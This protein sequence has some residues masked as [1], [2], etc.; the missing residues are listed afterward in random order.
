[1]SRNL[2][3]VGI[4]FFGMINGLPF[5]SPLYLPVLAFSAQLMQGPLFGN[6]SLIAYFASLMLS[7]G[8]II[9]SQ[10]S[11]PPPWRAR[12]SSSARKMSRARRS[13][14]VTPTRLASPYSAAVSERV[15]VWVRVAGKPA[16]GG[17]SAGAAACAS[18]GVGVRAKNCRMFLMSCICRGSSFASFQ[19]FR[20]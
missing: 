9:L 6:L 7:T 5:F 14:T 15:K 2:H 12:H 10:E 17:S 18:K 1:M 4:A 20:P 3:Y 11:S 16:G 13:F 19:K 8:T